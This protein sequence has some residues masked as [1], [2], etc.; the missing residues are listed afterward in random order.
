MYDV[1][2]FGLW[3]PKGYSPIREHILILLKRTKM[4]MKQGNSFFT[5]NKQIKKII[6]HRATLL[7]KTKNRY[8]K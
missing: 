7:S 4:R 2:V 5:S 3:T 6:I 1:G 8:K